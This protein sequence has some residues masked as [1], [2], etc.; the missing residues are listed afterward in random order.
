MRGTYLFSLF[1][2]ISFRFIPAYAGNISW[3]REKITQM[4]V[5]PRVC[6]EHLRIVYMSVHIFGSSP[7]MRGT[8]ILP[9][10]PFQSLRFIPA[11][12]GNIL[13]TRSIPGSKTVHPRICGEHGV[14]A[15]GDMNTGGSSPHMR[16]TFSFLIIRF[17]YVRFIPAYAGNII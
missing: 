3:K 4:P 15:R 11:Y 1:L 5:H 13:Q 17:P 12:A 16:G 8:L 2:A 9:S 14:L 7:H 10:F 6:G